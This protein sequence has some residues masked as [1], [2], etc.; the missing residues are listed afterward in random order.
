[1]GIGSSVVGSSVAERTRRSEPHGACDKQ[2]R[3]LADGVPAVMPA[4]GDR[5]GAHPRYVGHAYVLYGRNRSSSGSSPRLWND[6]FRCVAEDHTEPTRAAF[7][8]CA[9]RT[10]REFQGAFPALPVF[11]RPTSLLVLHTFLLPPSA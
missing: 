4:H 8:R 9:R 3:A 5:C 7:R 11:G 6:R 2:G 1:L 10:F